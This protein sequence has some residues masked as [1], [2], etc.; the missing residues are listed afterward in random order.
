MRVGKNVVVTLRYTV[1]D[2]DGE[3]LDAGKEP[4]VYLHG[5]HHGVF[6]AVEAALE[7]KQKGDKLQLKLQP[8]DAFGEYDAELVHVEARNR[9]PDN[10]EVGMRFERVEDDQDDEARVYTITEIAEDKVVI[11]GNHQLAGEA[12]VFDCTVLEVRPATPEELS[13]GHVHGPGG[14]HHH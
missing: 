14:H 7:G 4:L 5:G 8:E 3:M 9:F 13:H 12:L 6:P 1:R 11:D 2:S 10:I